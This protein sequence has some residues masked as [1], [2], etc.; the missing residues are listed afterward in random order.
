LTD[1]YAGLHLSTNL[2]DVLFG[3]PTLTKSECNKDPAKDNCRKNAGQAALI[4]AMKAQGFCLLDSEAW[5]F[6]KPKMSRSCR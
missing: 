3:T 1:G 5:H 4:S 6:E 2:Q